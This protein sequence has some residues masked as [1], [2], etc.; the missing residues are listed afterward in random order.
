MAISQI[1]IPQGSYGFSQIKGNALASV[2]ANFQDINIG[3]TL[4]LALGRGELLNLGNDKETVAFAL[5]F[6]ADGNSAL[7]FPIL[8][9]GNKVAIAN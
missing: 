8:M 9:L 4:H 7:N 5:A 2:E 6:L 1:T 3:D